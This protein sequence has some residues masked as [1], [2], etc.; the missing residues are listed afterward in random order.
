[1]NDYMTKPLRIENL[2]S[3]IQRHFGTKLA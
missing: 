1:M 3:A 2:Q